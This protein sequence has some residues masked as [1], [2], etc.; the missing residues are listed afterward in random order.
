MAGLLAHTTLY[1][2][3]IVMTIWVGFGDMKGRWLLLPMV[4]ASAIDKLCVTCC[5]NLHLTSKPDFADSQ[6]LRLLLSGHL[7]P[8]LASLP[9]THLLQAGSYD[10]SIHPQHLSVLPTVVF[11]PLFRHD[12][13]TMA[14]LFYLTLSGSSTCSSLY[15]RP[16]G[17]SSFWC[18]HVERPATPCRI[19]GLLGFQTMTRDL[20]VFPFLP[21]HY[22]VTHVNNITIHHFCLDTCGPCSN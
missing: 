14:A 17:V 11:H 10:V 7:L 22:H 16:A 8:S 18:D 21:R 9:R 2:F 13:Q 20:S 12:I 4:L 19:C 15:S 1:L 5:V 6:K 3:H